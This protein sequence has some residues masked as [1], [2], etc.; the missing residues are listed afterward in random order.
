MNEEMAGSYIP[1]NSS[2]TKEMI[3]CLRQLDFSGKYW[4]PTVWGL[5]TFVLEHTQRDHT[6][7]EECCVGHFLKKAPT[8]IQCG[9]AVRDSLA[10]LR[11][12]KRHAF[13]AYKPE[14][15]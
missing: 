6:E 14:K 11:S 4:Y 10:K 1:T 3:F 9:I 12:H 15:F 7:T 2:S 5:I 13:C 8:V